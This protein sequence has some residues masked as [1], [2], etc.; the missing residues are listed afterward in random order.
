MVIQRDKL[1]LTT[2]NISTMTLNAN[3]AS[4][5]LARSHKAALERNIE[6]AKQLLDLEKKREEE[7]EK[8]RGEEYRKAMEKWTVTKGRWEVVRQVAQAVVVGSG[9]DWTR[10]EELREWVVGWGD[11]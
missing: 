1:S 7:R 5:T 10:D 8:G 3:A 2:A 9:V 6:L 4:I 11:E